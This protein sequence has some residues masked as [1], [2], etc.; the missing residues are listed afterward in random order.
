MAATDTAKSK[1]PVLT[2]DGKM[3][4]GSPGLRSIN[5]GM[6]PTFLSGRLGGGERRYS[7]G[8]LNLG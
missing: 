4:A 5:L 6:A 7:H 8:M 3:R 1:I 2:L